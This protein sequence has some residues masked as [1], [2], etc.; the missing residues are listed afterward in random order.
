MSHINGALALVEARENPLLQNYTGLRLSV[1]LS[2]NVL[3]SCVSSDSPVPP[4]LTKLRSD[5]EPFLNK[6]DPKWQV[7]G[8]VVKYANLNGAIQDGCL[9]SSDVIARATELDL[10]FVSLANH[11]PSTW[12]YNTTYIE[13]ISERVFESRYDKY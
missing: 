1:R 7:S 13:E 4:A 5:L 10:E 8:L 3:I 11:M 6:E 9:P 2:T 12:L